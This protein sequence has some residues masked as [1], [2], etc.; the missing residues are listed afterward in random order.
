[1]LEM[2]VPDALQFVHHRRRLLIAAAMA[3]CNQND[4]GG[5]RKV[6]DQEGVEISVKSVSNSPIR[7]VRGRGYIPFPPQAVFTRIRDLDDRSS[8]DSNLSQAEMINDCV[9]ELEDGTICKLV[10]L[11][12]RGRRPASPRDLLLLTSTYDPQWDLG[13]S[14]QDLWV[15]EAI[16]VQHASV[17]VQDGIVRAQA[18][19]SGFVL[20]ASGTGTWVTYT[21]QLDPKGWLPSWLSN[22]VSI[23]LAL[24]VSKLKES[25]LERPVAIEMNIPPVVLPAEVSLPTESSAPRQSSSQNDSGLDGR[26]Q[27]KDVSVTFENDEYYP[28]S[29][30]VE[31]TGSTALI[32]R[33]QMDNS[34]MLQQSLLV[35]IEN[36]E[37]LLE[38]L[39]NLYLQSADQIQVERSQSNQSLRQAQ[40]SHGRY[41]WGLLFLS[42]TLG[43][44][45]SPLV[46]QWLIQALARRKR[47]RRRP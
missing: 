41:R 13:E 37:R 28:V 6:V 15:L 47:Q 11:T 39:I 40:R 10:H 5:W 38:R 25:L 24:V 9:S 12:F 20:Q 21:V 35:R 34:L 8:W 7:C 19:T 27:R 44:I 3:E 1:M 45:A 23:E 17:P 18:I 26:S 32:S 42:V 2:S 22:K 33:Q 36:V 14:P 4:Q 29:E 31:Q 46:F 43:V 30:V 16:S